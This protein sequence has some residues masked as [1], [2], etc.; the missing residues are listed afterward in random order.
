[1]VPTVAANLKLQSLA[2]IGALLLLLAGDKL[3]AQPSL[4]V[5]IFT[6][7][8]AYHS[9][10][11]TAVDDA[12]WGESA[13]FLTGRLSDRWSF[14]SEISFQIPKYRDE[15]T[16]VERLRVRYDLNRD[17]WVIFGK[18]HTPVNYWNDNFHHGRLFFPSINRPLSFQRFIPIHETGLRFAGNRLLG[19]DLGYDVMLGT[20]QSNGD[21]VFAEGVQ[22]YTGTLSWS[23]DNDFKIMASYYRDT[24]IDHGS[25]PF[26]NHG[27]D[28]RPTAIAVDTMDMGGL[29]S[30]GIMSDGDNRLPRQDIAYE[31]MSYSMFWRGETFTTLTELSVNRSSGEGGF[32]EAIYQYIGY[33]YNEDVTLY[34]L[35]DLVNVDAAEVHFAPGRESRYGVGLEY[36]F[37]LN[38]TLKLELRRRDDHTDRMDLYSN[39]IQAQISFGF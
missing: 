4:D 39:E 27:G 17:N 6:H 9:S 18:V 21:D 24:I 19:T 16:K 22:S 31:L 38:A 32:N 20:G 2:A 11:D 36:A 8:E 26:H 7:F 12:S 1:M 33:H 15:T 28:M 25:N 23:P 5:N 14:L 35:F 34:G 30:M 29:G 3:H 13:L 10:E 37:G